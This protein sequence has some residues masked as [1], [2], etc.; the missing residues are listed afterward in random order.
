MK[1]ILVMW[2][3]GIDSTYTLAKLLKETDYNIHAHHVTLI[4]HEK[5]GESEKDACLSMIPKL[6]EIRDFTS[7]GSSIDHSSHGGFIPFDMA[8]VCFEAGVCSRAAAYDSTRNAFD[9]WMIGT[10]KDEGHWATRWKAIAPAVDAACWPMD[11][12]K[13]VLHDL[14]SKKA[15]MEYLNNLGI[16]HLCWFCRMPQNGQSCCKCK[17]CKEVFEGM[18]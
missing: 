16:L 14:V 4:N 12:P 3:G 13:F 11:A 9:E 17:T 15:E 6:K 8:V 7:S 1:N 10:H 2:S 5:R 18:Q